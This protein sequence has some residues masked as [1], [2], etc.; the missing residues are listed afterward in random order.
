MKKL[1]RQHTLET[2]FILWLVIILFIVYGC[3]TRKVETDKTENKSEGITI[4][5]NYT[6]A[7]KTIFGSSF[8][9]TPFDGLKPML[10]DGK[11]YDNVIVSGATTSEVHHNIS[12]NTK[13]NIEKTIVIEK[14]K[15]SERTDYT[16]LYLGIFLITAVL[17]W[18]WF[19]LKK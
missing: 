6:E 14:T 8:T 4:E 5:N 7:T 12:K 19:Y 15:K 16:I 11:K 9:Y 18:L 3:G 13:Y 17:I 10:I 2:A 1:V